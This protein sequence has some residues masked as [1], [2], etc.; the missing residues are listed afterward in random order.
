VIVLLVVAGQDALAQVTSAIQG[1]ITDASGAVISGVSV[2]V[3]NAA[4]GIARTAV[5]APDGYYCV[6]DLLAG[7]YE[8][9]VEQSGFKTFVRKA[10]PLNAQVMLSIDVVLEVGA[11]NQTVEVTAEPPQ[12]ETTESRIS[13]AVSARQIESPPAIG[14]G[15]IWLTMTTPGIQGKAEDGRPWFI[16]RALPAPASAD[17]GFGNSP[18][19][20]GEECESVSFSSRSHIGG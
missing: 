6:A 15:L 11:A 16:G 4:T 20:P 10:I 5:S 8:V 3:T 2:K 9:R 14:R 1:R 12:I 19:H 17:R 18:T 13:E 7:P